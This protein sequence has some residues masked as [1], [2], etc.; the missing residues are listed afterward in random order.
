MGHL[1]GRLKG[2]LGYKEGIEDLLGDDPL[3]ISDEEMSE[4]SDIELDTQK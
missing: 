2:V 3:S 1:N 4:D